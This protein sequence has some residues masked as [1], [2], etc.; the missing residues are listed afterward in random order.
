MRQ[1]TRGLVVAAMTY[2]AVLAAVPAGVLRGEHEARVTRSLSP[3]TVQ[4]ESLGTGTDRPLW[5]AGGTG[6]GN[7]GTTKSSTRA[8]SPGTTKGK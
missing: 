7:P 3:A 2:A 6:V 4:E 5:L 1:G 8:G